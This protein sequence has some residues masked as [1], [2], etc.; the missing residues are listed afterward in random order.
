MCILVT[1]YT[2]GD[3]NEVGV[4]DNMSNNNNCYCWHQKK[5]R[6][7]IFVGNSL[8]CDTFFLY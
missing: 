1:H 5:R 8:T 4:R 2:G 3:E 6:K 7:D